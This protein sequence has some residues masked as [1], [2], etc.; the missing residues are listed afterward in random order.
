LSSLMNAVNRTISG[1]LF[2]RGCMVTRHTPSDDVR[3]AIKWLKP[4]D[5]GRDLIRLGGDG[6]GGYLV[7]DDLNGIKYCFSPGVS[8]VADFENDLA[9][10]GI[11]S[12]MADYSVNGPPINRP[13]FVFDKKFLGSL[14]NDQYFT[15]GAWKA[16]RL[17]GYSDDLLLQMD[18]EGSEYEVI[19]NASTEVL[20][21]FRIMVIEFHALQQLLDPFFCRVFSACVEKLS[22]H[23][24]VAHVHPNNGCGFTRKGDIEIPNVV[25]VTLYSKRRCRPTRKALTFPHPLDRDN[26]PDFPSLALPAS[27]YRD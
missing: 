10:R 19:A 13:E 20:S 2:A 26:S 27:W 9:N 3:A 22:Q 18:I 11:Q 25:E 1:A 24:K 7:P 12:F 17:N 8:N 23:F 15:L 14:D 6:D 21:Q 16:L 5:C 4:Q